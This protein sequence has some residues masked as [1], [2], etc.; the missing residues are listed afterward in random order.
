[1]VRPISGLTLL[2]GGFFVFVVMSFWMV[3]SNFVPHTS[4][5]LIDWLREDQYYCLLLPLT[6]PVTLVVSYLKW[7]TST[8]FQHN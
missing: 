8:L 4:N 5:W 7:F 6:V 3:L 1:M 2:L